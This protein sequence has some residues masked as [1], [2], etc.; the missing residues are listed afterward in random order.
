VV[1]DRQLALPEGVIRGGVRDGLPNR[2]ARYAVGSGTA[3]LA[4]GR[5]ESRP[6]S[7][8][9]IPPTVRSIP[10]DR[11]IDPIPPTA[12]MQPT[13]A[14][15]FH[16]THTLLT[17][18]NTHK[19]PI[20]TGLS[21]LPERM[22]C[23]PLRFPRS[24]KQI[25]LVHRCRKD[26]I[27]AHARAGGHDGRTG[28]QVFEYGTNWALL[29]HRDLKTTMLEPGVL[30]RGHQGVRSPGD[31]LQV[32]RIPTT[33]QEIVPRIFLEYPRRSGENERYSLPY[34]NGLSSKTECHG[35]FQE[36]ENCV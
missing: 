1:C 2:M 27:V 32:R 24:Y 16:A 20:F 17:I 3:R 8:D 14:L 22:I 10:T 6:F 23:V 29:G 26:T 11:P 13:R 4:R 36:Q 34:T 5:D 18:A 31:D 28:C 15:Q 25:H 21:T 7:I 9:P 19:T 12:R 30:N 35:T 33:R